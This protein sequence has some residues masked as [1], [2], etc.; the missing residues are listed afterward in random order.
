MEL[1]ISWP[2]V[3]VAI[4][5]GMVIAMAWY[6]D[7]GLG[8][9]WRELTGVTKEDST[10]GGKG[11][12]VILMASIVATAAVLAASF[13]VVSAFF[14]DNSVWLSLAVG[15][16]AWIG[17]SFSTLLQH[18]V[19]EQK[20]ARLTTINSAYQLALFLGMALPIGLLQ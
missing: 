15:L 17:F 9:A 11:P 7:W 13:A 18:N 5:V 3:V 16:I 20:P 1:T 14:S 8:P 2:A 10:Q 6:S 19:F 12:L 4:A